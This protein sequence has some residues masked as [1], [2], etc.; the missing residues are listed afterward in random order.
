MSKIALITVVTVLGVGTA[1]AQGEVH[2]TL[3]H[4]CM[5]LQEAKA[6]GLTNA[7]TPAIL[8]AQAVSQYIL[9]VRPSSTP[10]VGKLQGFSINSCWTAKGDSGYQIVEIRN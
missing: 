9:K 6:L 1:G 2:H 5:T 3:S 10:A 7:V 4:A 8:D